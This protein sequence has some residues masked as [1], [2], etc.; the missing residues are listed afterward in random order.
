MSRELQMCVVKT[1]SRMK[2]AQRPPQFQ[3]RPRNLGK[4]KQKEGR[5][6]KKTR[7]FGPHPDRS[8][9]SPTTPTPHLHSTNTRT[10]TRQPYPNPPWWN[11]GGRTSWTQKLFLSVVFGRFFSRAETRFFS[12]W[13][14]R[15]VRLNHSED[16]RTEKSNVAQSRISHRRVVSR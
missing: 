11:T 10:A 2:N 6:R 5:E 12:R 7:H 9:S 16:V 3:E 15:R 8:P 14:S 1:F 13:G 4:T